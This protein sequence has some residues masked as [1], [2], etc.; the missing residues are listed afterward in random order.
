MAARHLGFTGTRK[1]MTRMQAET[2]GAILE[3]RGGTLHHGGALGADTEAAMIAEDHGV[4]IEVHLPTGH[5]SKDY[6]AR[7]RVIVDA[8]EEL[9]AAPAGMEEELRSGTWATIRYARKARRM[10]TIIWPDGSV[11]HDPSWRPQSRS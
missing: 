1:G 7:N 5:R 10:V 11:S 9:L 8:C 6:F 3:N 2:L 4:Q